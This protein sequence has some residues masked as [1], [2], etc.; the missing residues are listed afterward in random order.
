M[1]LPEGRRH[2]GH[3]DSGGVGLRDYQLCVVDRYR[4]CRDADLGDSASVQAGL[5]QLDQPF[6]RGDDDFRGGLRRPVPADPR[7][8]SVAGILAVPVS[9]H[10]ELLAAVPLAA[11]VGRVRGF[12]VRDHLGGVLVHRN[13]SRPG[14]AARPVAVEV[15]A[16][17]LWAA[18]GGLARFG[19]ALGAV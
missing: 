6:R 7:R 15:R 14:D 3:H 8:T 17:L 9:K 11:A 13:D 2:L 12:N 19:A 18:G 4:P 1:A 10:D 5:A 16:V